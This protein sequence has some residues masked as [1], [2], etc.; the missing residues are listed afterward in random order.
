M[1]QL[2]RPAQIDQNSQERARAARLARID[3]WG[4]LNSGVL[5][6]AMVWA[7]SPDLELPQ[8]QTQVLAVQ[9]IHV[10]VALHCLF[11]ETRIFG[12]LIKNSEDSEDDF[13]VANGPLGRFIYLTH[14]TIIFVAIHSVASL[15]SPFLSVRLALGTHK[16]ALFIDGLGCFVTVQFFTLVFFTPAF[17]IECGLWAARGV[18]YRLLEVAR[19]V[20]PLML[21]I[22]DICFLKHRGTLLL[23]MPTIPTT[24]ALGL[25]YGLVYTALVLRNR[26]ITGCWPYTFMQAFGSST[27][28]WAQFVLIQSII[29]N[30]FMLT[31]DLVVRWTGALW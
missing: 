15:L 28:Q 14:Q 24:M 4:V 2:L 6:L 31:L 9:V 16:V 8:V 17:S 10:A 1:M 7:V 21:G 29:I 22:L 25:S 27:L 23:A 5:Y 18:H 3:S 20:P 19:H 11:L 12:G 30:S 13:N 26:R